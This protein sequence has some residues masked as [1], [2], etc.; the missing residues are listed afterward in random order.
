MNPSTFDKNTGKGFHDC[1]FQRLYKQALF[2]DASVVSNK[3]RQCESHDPLMRA[4]T[5]F[6]AG[7]VLMI[8]P[9]LIFDELCLAPQY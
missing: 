3:R 1:K 8:K 2:H 9:L 4:V 5:G 7:R 6:T